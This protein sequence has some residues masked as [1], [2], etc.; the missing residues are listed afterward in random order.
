MFFPNFN[1]LISYCD[2]VVI[3]VFTLTILF[4]HYKVLHV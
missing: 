4:E 3:V 2:N 1:D